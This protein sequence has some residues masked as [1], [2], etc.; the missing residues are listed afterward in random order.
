ML[1]RVTVA[2]FF[3]LLVWGNL[4]AGVKAGL[5]CPDWP[6]CRGAVLPPLQFDVWMEFIH[7]VI[8]AVATICLILLSQKRLRSYPGTAKTVPIAALG[9]VA[10]EI[11]FG[12]L[13]VLLELPVQLTVVHFMIGLTVFLLVCLMAAFDGENIPARFSLRGYA[14][15]FLAVG[16]L[17]YCQASLGAYVRHAG[18]GLA[19]PDFPTCLG[20]WLPPVFSEMVLAH[21]SHRLLA[22][23]LALTIGALCAAIYANPNLAGQRRGAA[24]L[25]ILALIQIG[26]GAGVVQSGLHYAATAL[27]LAVALAM[28]MILVGMYSTELSRRG[29]KP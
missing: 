12:G 24:A 29:E 6:L 26:A 10:V 22:Y 17:L 9:L 20:A 5:A 28:M 7:R 21:F 13:V 2:L 14:G 18:A 23:C 25:L 15:I 1:G 4:V 19:C 27:H 8:A 3:V 16:V 11:A